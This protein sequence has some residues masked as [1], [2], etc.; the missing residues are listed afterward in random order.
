MQDNEEEETNYAEETVQSVLS[1]EK[2]GFCSRGSLDKGLA[3][4]QPRVESGLW[5][6]EFNVYQ[7]GNQEGKRRQ[8]HWNNYDVLEAGCAVAGQ[9]RTKQRN[10][11]IQV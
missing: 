9:M 2:T 8:S 5:F 1:A 10:L 4:Y 3:F 11:T 6:V 7:A